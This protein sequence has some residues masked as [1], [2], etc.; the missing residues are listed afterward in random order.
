MIKRVFADYPLVIIA[1]LLSAYGIAVVYSA[2]QTD[3]VQTSVATAYQRQLG[4]FVVAL[5]GAWVLTESRCA[6]WNGPAGRYTCSPSS[7]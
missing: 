2:G 3:V 1:L 7:C 5:V 4:W 6:S